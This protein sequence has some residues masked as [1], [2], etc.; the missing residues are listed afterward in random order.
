[1]WNE[2]LICPGNCDGV[3]RDGRQQFRVTDV[4]QCL[5]DRLECGL[6]ADVPRVSLIDGFDVGGC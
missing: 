6:F 5:F 1:M 3:F 2:F 4:C